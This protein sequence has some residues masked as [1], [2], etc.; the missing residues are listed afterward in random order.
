MAGSEAKAAGET[1]KVTPKKFGQDMNNLKEMYGDFKETMT[2]VLGDAGKFILAHKFLIALAFI[3][4]LLY[5]NKQFTIA[6]F[7]KKLED[8]LKG[9]RDW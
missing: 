2:E 6:Q 5:R 9:D 8:R 7:V 4:F 3:A 1:A